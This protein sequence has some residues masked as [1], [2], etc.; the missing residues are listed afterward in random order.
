[1]SEH[2]PRTA[3]ATVLLQDYFHRSVFQDLVSPRYWERFESRLERQVET[4]L[5]LLS[6]YGAHATFF[7]LGWIA[8]RYPNL[9]VRI[10]EAGHEVADAGYRVCRVNRVPREELTSDLRRSRRILESITDRRVWGF[11]APYLWLEERDTETL[12]A[13][14]AAGYRYDASV[15]PRHV[16]LSSR[17]ASRF[18]RTLALPDGELAEIPPSSY[19][20]AGLNSLIAGGTYL[21][22]V[23]HRFMHAHF[24]RWI[25]TRHEPYVLYFHPW[26][27]DP[28]Q[29]RVAA[30][31]PM[32]RLRQYRNLGRLRDTLPDYLREARFTSAREYLGLP[33]LASGGD[34]ESP[35]W[36]D[37]VITD[38]SLEPLRVASAATSR[39]SARGTDVSV[40]IP[41]FNE[42][43]T[44]PYLERALDELQRAA[45]GAYQFT[46][47]FVDDCSTDDTRRALTHRFGGR[48]DCRIVYHT[49]NQGVS[50]AIMSGIRAAD[51]ELVCS[52]DADCSYDPLALLDM[53]P[54]LEQG[55]DM[56]T[57]SPYH[58]D[59]V[60][61]G[62][63]GWRLFLSRSLSSIY[64]VLLRHKFA[65]Y[66]SCFRVYR[67]ASV[68]HTQ[69]A[70]GDFRGV[71]ELLAR[72][73]MGGGTLREFPAT[74][75]SRIFGV[76]KMKTLKTVLGHLKLLATLRRY[77][78]GRVPD[79]V[80][81]GRAIPAEAAPTTDGAGDPVTDP[82]S[83][84]AGIA[85]RAGQ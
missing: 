81:P 36:F 43:D 11:R 52:V 24:L 73:D 33:D 28:D 83:S 10:V 7:V 51:S 9:I 65:T 37:D 41:C 60:V 82:S 48:S 72:I 62:V 34:G 30:I 50:G 59:G 21:R 68:A 15:R 80:R 4:V 71:V 57:A 42:V 31:G 69:L 6:R 22:Q 79:A 26:E 16:S 56:V 64:H 5:A 44:L 17:D 27:L 85:S 47:I 13:L 49:H 74:L 55:V 25:S 38:T 75:Q 39:D 18:V 20:F 61:L 67:R 8:V 19:R 14:V 54:R 40:V 58:A 63:P 2:E 3:I 1:M 29:P 76:S 84:G 66:T 32:G 23:P 70:Y 78:P 12:G 46:F 53:I 45:L 35:E 77:R